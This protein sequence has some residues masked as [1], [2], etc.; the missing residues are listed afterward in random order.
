VVYRKGELSK[1]MMDRQWPHQVALPAYR[2]LG[3]SYLTIRFFCE[4]EGLSLR[5]GRTRCAAV[6]RTRSSFALPTVPTPNN[7]GGFSAVSSLMPKPGPVA[8][9]NIRTMR[10]GNRYARERGFGRTLGQLVESKMALVAILP[11]VQTPAGS[12]P[13]QFH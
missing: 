8:G 7:S 10:P 9:R 4:G 1:A 2:C 5:L 3:H 6:A 11:P 13:C 12:L